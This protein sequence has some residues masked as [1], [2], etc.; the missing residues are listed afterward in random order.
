MLRGFGNPTS[1]SFN[2]PTRNFAFLV[3]TDFA[4]NPNLPGYADCTSN[5]LPTTCQP[6][7]EA[8]QGAL[9]NPRSNR[10]PADQ[11][12]DLLDQ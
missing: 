2:D 8:V 5:L 12:A 10:G 4:N 7:Q 3:P 1:N 9:N 11:D 6:F